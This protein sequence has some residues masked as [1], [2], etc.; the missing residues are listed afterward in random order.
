MELPLLICIL[1]A[2]GPVLRGRV[3]EDLVGTSQRNLKAF[4]QDPHP[5]KHTLHYFFQE[6]FLQLCGCSSGWFLQSVP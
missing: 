3:N 1:C 5:V 4:L 2:W 6:S